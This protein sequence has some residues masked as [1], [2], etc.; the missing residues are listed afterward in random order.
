MSATLLKSDMHGSGFWCRVSGACRRCVA[1]VTCGRE[2]YRASRR[3]PEWVHLPDR[4]WRRNSALLV[5][6]YQEQR[7]HG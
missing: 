6:L 7:D 3:R 4:V 5:S 2:Q 1:K